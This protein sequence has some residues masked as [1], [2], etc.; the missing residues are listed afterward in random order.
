MH[1]I[2]IKIGRCRKLAKA[3]CIVAKLKA[4]EGKS[5]TLT[6]KYEI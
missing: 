5:A 1:N 2:E 6:L 4:K 3:A